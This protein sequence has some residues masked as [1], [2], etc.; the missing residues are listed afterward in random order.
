MMQNFFALLLVLMFPSIIHFMLGW[1]TSLVPILLSCAISVINWA[2]EVLVWLTVFAFLY[3][4]FNVEKVF[5]FLRHWCILKPN[6]SARLK[7]RHWIK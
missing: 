3:F 7:R 2:V 6:A 5:G 4:V 1:A